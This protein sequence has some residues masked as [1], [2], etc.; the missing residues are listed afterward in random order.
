MQPRATHQFPRLLSAAYLWKFAVLAGFF[1]IWASAALADKR[2]A[3]V[4]GNTSY[5]NSAALPN[6]RNDARAMADALAELGFAVT[7]AEDLTLSAM[8]AALRDFAR[9]SY[10]VQDALVFFAG[11]GM[12]FGGENWLLPVDAQLQTDLD[13]SFETIS[14]SAI[15][16][17]VG[18][19]RGLKLVILDACRDNPF[20]NTM[21]RRDTTRSLGRGLA[22]VEPADGTLVSFAA[23]A[24]QVASDGDGQNSPFTTALL[25]RMAQPGLELG[26]LFRE[27]RDAV[28]E[29]TGRRQEPF[30]Y[31]SL[32]ARAIYLNPPQEQPS[33]AIPAASGPSDAC[34]MA[35]SVWSAI[36]DS[37]SRSAL[38]GFVDSYGA[39]CPALGALAADRLRA[40][41]QP[42]LAMTEPQHCESL[43]FTW[44]MLG[45]QADI[46]RFLEHLPQDC[47][48]LRNSIA[49]HACAS[50][51]SPDAASPVEL[52]GRDTTQAL[53]IC[54]LA[55]DQTPDDAQSAAYLGRILS[56]R[57]AD[58]DAVRWYRVA[59]AGGHP[60]G[61]NNLG[62][63]YAEGAGVE[64]DQ[65]EAFRLYRLAA[66]AGLDVAMR[67]VGRAYLDG[68][69]VAPD[70]QEAAVWLQ[71]ATERSDIDATATLG[72]MYLNGYGVAQ[73]LDEA[74]RL[75][76]VA[77]DRGSSTGM[78]NLG[79]MYEQGEGVRQDH[80]EAL[81]WYRRAAAQGDIDAIANLGWMYLVGRG[82][83]IDLP[84]ALRLISMAAADGNLSA[85]NNLGYM[86]ENGLGVPQDEAQAFFWF[87]RAADSGHARAMVSAGFS[88]QKG[89]G[90]EQDLAA[91]RDY[92]AK[93]AE[94]GNATAMYNLAVL[95]ANGTG[96]EQDF[97]Q[98]FD[99]YV[100]SA[101][102]GDEDAM[103]MAAIYL[104]EGRSVERD[105]ERA[106]RY[107]I[108]AI[109]AGDNW[110]LEN[111]RERDAA[112]IQ[113]VQR[114][115]RDLGENP[116]PADGTWGQRSE[117]ALLRY[118]NAQRTKQ[119]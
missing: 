53:A 112:V 87:K 70:A 98:A 105:A 97:A 114:V 59:A 100:R 86:H 31:G 77:A 6:A 96:V 62:V 94:V 92:Y 72:W 107:Y 39:Q 65:T 55:L 22:R 68:A 29:S 101:A 60:I 23:R 18:G 61:L 14:L 36:A 21:G 82:T 90:V 64:I 56:A 49:H 3:L 115:L 111:A 109:L 58:E 95:Y 76:R 80:D 17:A 74:Y 24:G 2:V 75:T 50:L 113:A 30:T 44:R 88:Y 41:A 7:L 78:T 12:E 43:A 67:N 102:A 38:Q 54:Q 46:A 32:P 27:V 35:L 5:E 106:A 26:L 69:G 33:I 85:M 28:F 9:A 84:E 118:A 1:V 99:W 47:I 66:E 89:R 116:G 104:E 110:F 81:N 42:T 4:I 25:A 119:Q 63:A 83:E 19:A 11:H 37:N 15:L 13:V 93:A 34:A 10:G 108:D 48:S 103:T 79:Y 52:E 117:A 51:A 91:A 73:D 8:N 20:L 57:G 45:P 71:R 16:Q 40:L